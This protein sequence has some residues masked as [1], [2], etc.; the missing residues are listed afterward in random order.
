MTIKSKNKVKSVPSKFFAYLSRL[1]WIKRWGL[2]RNAYQ[3][4]VME[5]SWEV[6]TIAHALELIH[7]EYFDG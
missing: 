6:A 4:N 1:R 5:H 7:N 3:E 2:M